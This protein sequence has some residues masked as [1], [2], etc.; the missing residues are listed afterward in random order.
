MSNSG[1][2]IV[3]FYSYKGG[4]G[5]TMALANL[6]WVLASAGRRVLLIDWDLE[7]PGLHRYLRPFLV[8]PELKS[9]PGLI[10]YVW[11]IVDQT[12][13]PTQ[14]R[15]AFNE[16][17]GTNFP[18]LGDYAISV[19][20]EFKGD[21]YIDF[22]PAGR[23][24]EQYARR[25]NSFS[26]DNFYERLGGGRFLQ[27]AREALRNNYEYILIDSR[28]GV[29]DT[30]GICTI[31]MPDLLVACFTLNHQSIRGVASIVKS[32]HAQRPELPIFPVP[33]RVERGE[34]DL[35]ANAMEFAKR[36]FAPLLGHVAYV[37]EQYDK[38]EITPAHNS[39]WADV[40]TP[41][42]TFYAF[43]EVPAAFKDDID[44]HGTVLAAAQRLAGWIS[45]NRVTRLQREN[46][47][48]PDECKKVVAAYDFKKDDKLPV[49]TSGPI[50]PKLARSE[51]LIRWR[52]W[53]RRNIVAYWW[54]SLYAAGVF[55]GLLANLPSYLFISS[56]TTI[57][58]APKRPANDGAGR[59]VECW[60]ERDEFIGITACIPEAVD[61]DG[62]TQCWPND[63][64]KNGRSIQVCMDRFGGSSDKARSVAPS[65][66]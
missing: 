14:K 54:L 4:T 57:V 59:N 15:E 23:Q 36:T 12:L 29:S 35:F 52:R 13:T 46:L 43:G 33:T 26:W 34:K 21:G 41:Y 38:S 19:E 20:W 18:S 64:R 7:A 37:P 53:G 45:D 27:H 42:D 40:Q 49:V 39:Y 55:G 62:H 47:G 56:A 63:D 6:A 17:I 3:T 1:C 31:Q 66:P 16:T 30:S 65:R 2:T 51:M 9:T 44:E 50:S 61:S 11:D 8:D 24:D 22:I 58:W 25:V 10:D 60:T 5:R 28:T 48:T 32:I